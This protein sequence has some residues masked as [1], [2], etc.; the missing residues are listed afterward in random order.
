MSGNGYAS[1]GRVKTEEEIANRALEERIVA[2]ITEK[3]GKKFTQ[4]SCYS[5]NHGNYSDPKPTRDISVSLGDFFNETGLAYQIIINTET[6][7]HTVRKKTP[8]YKDITDIDKEIVLDCVSASVQNG[9]K[10]RRSKN[11]AKRVKRNNMTKKFKSIH[12][13]V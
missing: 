13:R 5:Q 1:L 11:K 4:Y 8:Y 9:G 7:Q 3:L 6:N 10:T 12:S 2:C